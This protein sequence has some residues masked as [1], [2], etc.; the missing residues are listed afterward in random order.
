MLRHQSKLFCRQKF[1]LSTYQALKILEFFVRFFLFDFAQQ[2]PQEN[3]DN[4]E[5]Y[6][7]LVDAA[8][9]DPIV[10]LNQNSKAEERENSVS[11]NI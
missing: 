1:S 9:V 8:L 5:L 2:L 6:F 7:T 10:I 3:A 4:L 11:F